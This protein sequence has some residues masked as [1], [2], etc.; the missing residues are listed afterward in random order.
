MNGFAFPVV[1]AIGSP[2]SPGTPPSE[3]TRETDDPQSL[4]RA[5]SKSVCRAEG[6]KWI[7]E[8][9]TCAID[10][11]SCKSDSDFN[12]GSHSH[13]SSDSDSNSNSSSESAN[14][15]GKSK[16]HYNCSRTGQIFNTLECVLW[17]R[18]QLILVYLVHKHQCGST[19]TM[20]SHK[21]TMHG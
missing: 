18:L 12:S 2:G 14:V 4:E 11:D 5:N 10:S 7:F 3:A 9:K 21:H 15:G 16:R 19:I 8:T 1:E 6:N 20:L 13:S 17:S